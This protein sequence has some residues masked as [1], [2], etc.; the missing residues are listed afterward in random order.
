MSAK[1]PL[2]NPDKF[3]QRALTLHHAGKLS[4]AEGLYKTLLSYFP[5]QIELLTTLGI[6]LLQQG[7]SEAGIQQL[8]KS[9]SVNPNQPTAL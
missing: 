4:D 7:R 3:Y 8:K 2:F 1:K 5:N 9:L 6:L